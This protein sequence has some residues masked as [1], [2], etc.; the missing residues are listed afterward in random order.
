MVTPEQ[1]EAKIAIPMCRGVGLASSVIWGNWGLELS[2]AD[3]EALLTRGQVT[4]FPKG[5]AKTHVLTSMV[6]SI[7]QK[8]CYYGCYRSIFHSGVVFFCIQV[9]GTANFVWSVL[10]HL[11]VR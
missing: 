10:V 8:V 6:D 4:H 7:V 11:G 3:S 1:P 2:V 9:S 5:I